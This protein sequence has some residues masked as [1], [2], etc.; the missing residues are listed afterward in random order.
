MASCGGAPPRTSNAPSPTA[1]IPL[2][3]VID[4]A[5]EKDIQ[6]ICSLR[7]NEG[8]T[9]G[10]LNANRYMFSR[11]KEEH[12]EYMIG[13]DCRRP[14]QV[15]VP[16]LR[17]SLR[18]DRS[19]S[20]IIEEVCDRYGADGIEI[21]DYVRTFFRQSEIEKNTPLLTEFMGDIRALLDRIGERRG[22]RLMLAARV[23]PRED[24]NLSVGMDVRRLDPR[25]IRRSRSRRLRRLPVRPGHRPRM[26]RRGGPCKRRA[27]LL[28]LGPNALR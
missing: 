7:I 18:S 13:D 8:G 27:R 4:R 5:H 10:G 20:P 2:Q 6:I 1:S 17:H 15:H 22:D 14:R 21:D 25:T 19:A 11:L 3:V 23:H 12:P 16:Q 26:D 9:G 28:T 24:A